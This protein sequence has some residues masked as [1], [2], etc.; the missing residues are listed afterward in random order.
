MQSRAQERL[1]QRSRAHDCLP[2]GCP[3]KEGSL[4]LFKCT[5]FLYLP[6]KLGSYKIWGTALVVAF[7]CEK[8]QA[9][10]AL[11]WILIPT[12]SR[13][14]L[15]WCCCIHL[16]VALWPHFPLFWMESRVSKARGSHKPGK[17]KPCH[18]WQHQNCSVRVAGQCPEQGI[19]S[20]SPTKALNLHSYNL[21]LFKAALLEFQNDVGWKG[22]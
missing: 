22:L 12:G 7:C 21:K 18:V 13:N 14:S 19:A 1:C 2:A 10:A 8:M 5:V 11:C 4:S 3:A 6:Q 15:C 20:G 17:R 16:Q 9:L